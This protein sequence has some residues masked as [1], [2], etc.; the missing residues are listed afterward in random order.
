MREDDVE[1]ALEELSTIGGVSVTLSHLG[2]A[3]GFDPGEAMLD[4]TED[5]DPDSVPSL[6]PLWTVTF[7]GECSLAERASSACPPNIGNLEVNENACFNTCEQSVQ[8]FR[9]AVIPSLSCMKNVWVFLRLDLR[10]ERHDYR[11]LRR[12]VGEENE[13]SMVPVNHSSTRSFT[14]STQ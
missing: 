8:R 5:S 11:V 12:T 6:F 13:E 7:D 14:C 4:F 10:C 2:L 1:A 9:S 3:L